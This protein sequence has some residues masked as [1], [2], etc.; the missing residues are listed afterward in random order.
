MKRINYAAIAVVALAGVVVG[1]SS[2]RVHT[3]YNPRSDFRQL[4]TY[5][6]VDQQP[7]SARHPAVNSP[8]V[9]ERV[10]NAVDAQLVGR[11]FRRLTSG[12]PDFW[13]AYYVVAT[14]KTE[15][16]TD[17]GAYGYYGRYYSPSIYTLEF[18]EGTLV[19]DVINAETNELMWRG[20]ATK[21]LDDDPK[22]DAV[23]MYVRQAVEKILKEFPPTT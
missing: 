10:Q 21:A 7:K 5:M 23:E 14:D 8:L 6:W 11:G 13:V 20:W 17:D 4:R 22:P 12:T 18:V 19:I 16:I 2:T 15:I 3:D 1:C 9:T